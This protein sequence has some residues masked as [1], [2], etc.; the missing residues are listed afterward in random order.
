MAT[1]GYVGPSSWTLF[2][3]IVEGAPRTHKVLMFWCP[4]NPG[5]YIMCFTKWQAP[6]LLHWPWFHAS[7]CT[8]L[9]YLLLLSYAISIANDASPNKV[10]F[11][12]LRLPSWGPV[13]SVLSARRWPNISRWD[14]EYQP[15][16]L[17][18]KNQDVQETTLG[19]LYQVY[20]SLGWTWIEA[21][22]K[23]EY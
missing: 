15:S 17:V 6:Y 8:M 5:T 1:H 20:G 23:W 12:S 10:I 11:L 3:T 16:M 13:N 2:P 14:Q 4:K 22:C 18:I 9:G 7:I 19:S 21:K